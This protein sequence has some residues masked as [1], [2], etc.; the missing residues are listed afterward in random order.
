MSNA[1]NNIRWGGGENESTRAFLGRVKGVS[2]GND[3]HRRAPWWEAE[4]TNVSP[5][6]M[7]GQ[8]KKPEHLVFT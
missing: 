4:I 2:G 8:N 6:V 7:S 1:E 3:V 5:S